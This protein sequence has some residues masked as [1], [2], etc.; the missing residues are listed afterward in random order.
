MFE[1]ILAGEAEVLL[2]IAVL[3]LL[4]HE[5]RRRGRIARYGMI[6]NP[7]LIIEEETMLD[8]LTAWWEGRRADRKRRRDVRK[9]RRRHPDL[10]EQEEWQGT[11]PVVIAQLMLVHDRQ[12]LREEGVEP[13]DSRYPDLY[14][15]YYLENPI[16]W[17]SLFPFRRELRFL[18]T[19]KIN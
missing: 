16:T 5:P 17:W 3:P 6:R 1:N 11:D 4:I 19:G 12:R 10:V 7:G 18:L 8:S 14:D 15:Y 9:N 13:D 2:V